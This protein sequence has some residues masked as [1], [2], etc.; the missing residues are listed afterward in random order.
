MMRGATP[1]TPV[2]RMRLKVWRGRAQLELDHATA[3]GAPLGEYIIQALAV[4]LVDR[5][6]Q[7]RKILVEAP[8]DFEHSL[9]VVEENIAPH[10]RV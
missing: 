2:D 4:A 8:K 10:R 7:R 6:R 9:L 1:A 3:D 5:A